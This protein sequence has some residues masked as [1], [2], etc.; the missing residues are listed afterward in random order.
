M[1]VYQIR[2]FLV[3]RLTII[4]AV[5]FVLIRTCQFVA[6]DASRF[7]VDNLDPFMAYYNITPIQMA[8]FVLVPLYA[9]LSV[10]ALRMLENANFYTRLK[11]RERVVCCYALLV[12]LQSGVFAVL[13]NITGAII[14]F[15]ESSLVPLA[16]DLTEIVFIVTA[17]TV[18]DALFF[19]VC[20][21]LL[22]A[23]HALTKKVPLAALALFSYAIWDFLIDHIPGY[24]GILPTVGWRLTEIHYPASFYNASTK[25]APL[26]L[27]TLLLL[28]INLLIARRRDFAWTSET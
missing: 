12:F 13:I 23:V 9:V 10:P 11:S 28:W 21:L 1:S 19:A 5:T 16:F 4:I 25:T 6:F 2:C 27:L 18:L 3:N 17:A 24:A 22:L 20:A 14:L 7:R 26:L 15:V 8:V